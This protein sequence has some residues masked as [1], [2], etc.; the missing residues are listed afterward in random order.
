MMTAVSPGRWKVFSRKNLE[1][2]WEKVKRNRGSAGI[3][4]VT[5]EQF[6]ARKE[7]FLALLSRC[8][9]PSPVL[10]VKGGMGPIDPSRSS[11]SKSGSLTEECES[12]EY[13][14]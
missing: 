10:S 6:E 3:D 4:K 7:E 8:E 5:I 2:A 1:L 14:P 13:R 11:E 12:W 9:T